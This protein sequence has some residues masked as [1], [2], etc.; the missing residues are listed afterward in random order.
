MEKTLTLRNYVGDG[1]DSWGMY[2]CTGRDEGKKR[3]RVE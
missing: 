2:I 1:E 3:I